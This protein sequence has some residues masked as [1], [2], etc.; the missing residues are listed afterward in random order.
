MPPHLADAHCVWPNGR[1]RPSVSSLTNEARL[2]VLLCYQAGLDL[3]CNVREEWANSC[4]GTNAR[5]ASSKRL[6][7]SR[8]TWPRSVNLEQGPVSSNLCALGRPD[9]RWCLGVKILGGLY[10]CDF[11]GVEQLPARIPDNHLLRAP[12]A[13]GR[14]ESY[15]LA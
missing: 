8:G 14:R 2:T 7:H 11:P 1:R 5:D 10:G 3:F 9:N 13:I 6:N 15:S 12:Q 4:H